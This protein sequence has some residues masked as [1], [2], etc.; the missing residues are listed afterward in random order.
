MA[1]ANAKGGA[2]GRRQAQWDGRRQGLATA[3]QHPAAYTALVR[4]GHHEGTPGALTN[5]A[6]AVVLL[7]RR[8]GH[9]ALALDGDGRS[10]PIKG[11]G[12]AHCRVDS[13]AMVL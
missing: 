4:A 12:E 2:A 3:R 11:A 5:A 6:V 13:P 1:T 10:V 8:A 7:L 9:K